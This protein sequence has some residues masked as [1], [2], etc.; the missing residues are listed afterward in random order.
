M[1]ISEFRLQ[2][3]SGFLGYKHSDQVLP[4]YFRNF[5]VCPHCQKKGGFVPSWP[6]ERRRADNFALRWRAVSLGFG[7]QTDLFPCRKVFGENRNDD[8]GLPWTWRCGITWWPE[9]RVQLQ[10]ISRFQ[11]EEVT[12]AQ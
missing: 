12:L 2:L 6:T 3:F 9:A 10:Q 11:F 8:G 4:P 1:G 7:R 5:G